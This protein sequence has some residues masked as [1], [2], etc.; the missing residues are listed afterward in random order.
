[1]SVT[2]K[3]LI[4]TQ[5]I[6][7][8]ATT[9]YTAPAGI[10]TIIDGFTVTNTSGSTLNYTLWLVPANQSPAVS[11]LIIPPTSLTGPVV[12]PIGA[13][14]PLSALI[15]NQVLNSGDSIVMLAST[16]NALVVRVSGRECQ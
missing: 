3:C 6:P 5:F 10:R 14:N 12:S 2:A 8:V 16:A 15:P 1:M 9:L 13:G 4:E 11:N 7:N